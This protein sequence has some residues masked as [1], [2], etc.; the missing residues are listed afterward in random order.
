MLGAVEQQ[1]MGQ[2]DQEHSD[3]PVDQQHVEDDMDVDTSD[4]EPGG[5]LSTYLSLPQ[6]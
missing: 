2:E 3:Q 4:S 6:Y 1:D 5:V